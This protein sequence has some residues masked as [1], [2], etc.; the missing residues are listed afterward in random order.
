[1]R[2][3][4][5]RSVVVVL[6][7]TVLAAA[8]SASPAAAVTH[9]VAEQGTPGK[10]FTFVDLPSAL[11]MSEA[12]ET[13]QDLRLSD[14]V[15]GR[16]D[17]TS[18]V[19]GGQVPDP[20]SIEVLD[21]GDF[22][23][24][25]RAGAAV[26]EA[27]PAGQL[28]WQYTRAE[29]ASLDRPFSAQRFSRDGNDY[30]LVADRD[31]YRVWVVDADYNVVWQY[32][33]TGEQGLGPNH[34]MDPF[35]ARYSPE[36]GGTVLIADNLKGCRVIEV[37]YSDYQA[38]APDN[39]FTA[40]SIVWSYGEPGVSGNG[41]GQLCKPHSAQRL[42]SGNV[43]IC[44]AGDDTIGSRVL[45]VDRATR[46]ISWQYGVTGP[47]G[48][49]EGYLQEANFAS[50]LA[51]GDT[52]I[53][54]TLAGRVLRV[55][56]DKRIEQAWDQNVI[57]KPEGFGSGSSSPRAAAFTADGRLVVA[58]SVF[59]QI[60]AEGHV[61]AAVATSAPLDCGHPGVDKAFVSL[62][63]K[64]DTREA[65][66]GMQVEYRVGT[67][68]WR[69]C[70]FKGGSRRYD[71]KA[72]THGTTI[73]YRV[74]LKTQNAARTPVL[75]S[76]FL[77][78]TKASTGG[79]GGGGGGKPGGSGNSGQGGTYTYPSA[80]A[81]GTG[82]SG[83]G[84]GSGTYGSGT[85]SGTSGG[86]TGSLPASGV[87]GGAAVTNSVDVPVQSTGGDTVENVQG[88]PTQGEVGV[89]GVPLR[90]APGAQ[91]PE[92]E[93]PGPSVPVLALLAA[94]LFVAAAFFVPWPFMAAHLRGITGFD[95]TRHKRVLPFRPLGK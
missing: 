87:G 94:G 92:P 4:L 85:G 6:A 1:M 30:T 91:A 11:Q 5:P 86:G 7:A 65:G 56:S 26:F 35:Y 24:A 57:A 32:G 27:T 84:T 67:G 68:A 95:H 14:T 90:A 38:S 18:P 72:G 40:D 34:L 79:N 16:I 29:E 78:A 60:A 10:P 41:P 28:V 52:L 15:L 80:A 25:D 19:Y 9:W 48:T 69:V 23:F 58:D 17:R 13:G 71:F 88:Y 37:R 39:G 74:T 31:A 83:I 75:D 36:D 70:A 55:T 8:W 21:N 43:L 93:R 20:R 59:Q 53:T 54:D 42:A 50:R 44:D 62:T 49:G 22:L 73:A 64:G 61:A 81:G 66:T 2:R 51:D 3:R 47:P 63:W 12:T 89:S 77:Q 46:A 76:I 33:V 82:T 45:E